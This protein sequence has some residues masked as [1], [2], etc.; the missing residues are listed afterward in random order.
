MPKCPHCDYESN[1]LSAFCPACGGAMQTAEAAPAQENSPYAAPIQESA[2][3]A[4]PR[5][6]PVTLGMKWLRFLVTF[7][8]PIDIIN[9]IL[10]LLDLPQ[11]F[12]LLGSAEVSAILSNPEKILFYASLLLSVVQVPLLIFALWGLFKQKW[13]GVQALLIN[14][15][16]NAVYAVIMTVVVATMPASAFSLPQEAQ[17]LLYGSGVTGRDLQ[18]MQI[19][20]MAVTAAAM[21]ALFFANRVYF[22]KRRG[23]FLPE[24][25]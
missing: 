9:G 3:Y 12:T 2:P 5:F 14:Y 4:A 24:K 20:S 22:L 15:L 18:T 23:F 10:S 6:R 17:T 16:I 1:V 13:S 7:L 8:L 11:V 21:I 19:A 25:Q